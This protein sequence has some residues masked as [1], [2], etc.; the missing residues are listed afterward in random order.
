[1]IS[2]INVGSIFELKNQFFRCISEASTVDGVL[3]LKNAHFWQLDFNS[4][5][6]TVDVR[7]RRDADDQM[8]L[9]LVTE[10]LCSVINVLTI[11]VCGIQILLLKIDFFAQKQFYVDL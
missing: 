7:V 4:I 6:G 9:S 3:E 1:M 11:Q 10:K 5:A 2:K 8:V